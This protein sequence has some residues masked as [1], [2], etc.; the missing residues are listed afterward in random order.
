MVKS[1]PRDFMPAIQVRPP[2]RHSLL[3]SARLNPAADHAQL[4][5]IRRLLQRR[6]VSRDERAISFPP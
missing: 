4:R 1:E 6:Q 3:C 5:I 2:L